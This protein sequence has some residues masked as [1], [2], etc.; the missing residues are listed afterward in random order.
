MQPPHARELTAFLSRDLQSIHNQQLSHANQIHSIY[1]AIGVPP[2]ERDRVANTRDIPSDFN[3][4]FDPAVMRARLFAGIDVS[5]LLSSMGAGDGG[6]SRAKSPTKPRHQA[7]VAFPATSPTAWSGRSGDFFSMEDQQSLRGDS[8]YQSHN[9]KGKGKSSEHGSAEEGTARLR[10][11]LDLASR[12]FG[13]NSSLV[14]LRDSLGLWMKALGWNVEADVTSAVD[15]AEDG[16][17]RARDLIESDED[18]QHGDERDDSVRLPSRRTPRDQS[19]R[20][21]KVLTLLA[22]NNELRSQEQAL[23]HRRQNALALQLAYQLFVSPPSSYSLSTTLASPTTSPFQITNGFSSFHMSPTTASPATFSSTAS[24]SGPQRSSPL[25]SPH[26]ILSHL[27]SRPLRDTLWE[28]F[29]GV[30]ELHSSVSFKTIGDRVDAMFAWAESAG[31]STDD[32]NEDALSSISSSSHGQQARSIGQRTSRRPARMT[33][34]SAPTLSFYALA[35]ASFALGAQAHS[36]KLAHGFEAAADGEREDT[37]MAGSGLPAPTSIPQPSLP[38]NLTPHHLHSLSRAALLAHKQLDMPPCLDTVLAYVLGWL[39]QMHASDE[40]N[41][42]DGGARTAILDSVCR[43]VGEMVV[44]ARIMGLDRSED[45]GGEDN[46]SGMGA[47]EKEM[48]KRVWWELK[49]WDM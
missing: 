8:G 16:V 47:W 13:A 17:M 1:D 22:S 35:C 11:Q 24:S 41:S 36:C 28:E 25:I 7:M 45:S 34:S 20:S 49:C 27:P 30:M 12:V 43:D 38:P 3:L 14:A 31:G 18:Y 6:R 19:R 15:M 9:G 29:R 44:L 26:H 39:F 23:S 40:P 21:G 10:A 5:A 37:Y 33:L 46:D 42:H 32:L 48:R 2:D 4:R